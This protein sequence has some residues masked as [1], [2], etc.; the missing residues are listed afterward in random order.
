MNPIFILDLIRLFTIAGVRP[1]HEHQAVHCF[2]G[3]QNMVTLLTR[4]QK[5]T[6]LHNPGTCAFLKRDDS[7]I[8]LI[9]PSIPEHDGWLLP[10][11][12]DLAKLFEIFTL[13]GKNFTLL[14]EHNHNTAILKAFMFKHNTGAVVQILWRATPIFP[15]DQ[16]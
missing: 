7:Q 11:E 3:L 14:E 6:C 1:I 4:D 9:L 10:T 5:F 2:G 16:K 12:E 13:E 8:E 15:A